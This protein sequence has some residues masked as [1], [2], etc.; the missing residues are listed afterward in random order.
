MQFVNTI[1]LIKLSHQKFR[2][3]RQTL[4][5]DVFEKSVIAISELRF[6]WA[7]CCTFAEKR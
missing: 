5:V 3:A 6:G 2:E 7:C 4:Q 1:S